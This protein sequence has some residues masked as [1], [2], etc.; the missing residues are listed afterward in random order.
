LL[1]AVLEAKGVYP[2]TVVSHAEHI[3]ALITGSAWCGRFSGET[4]PSI[5]RSHPENAARVGNGH[6][7]LPFFETY[8]ADLTTL[9]KCCTSGHCDDCRDSQAV[10]SWQLVSLDRA[11]ASRDT[12]KTWIEVSESYWSQFVWTPFHRSAQKDVIETVSAADAP[13]EADVT[14]TAPC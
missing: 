14:D 3:G 13:C 2:D 7:F 11:L 1:N 12:L 6:P 10:Y 8:K 4:S 9:E 5:S